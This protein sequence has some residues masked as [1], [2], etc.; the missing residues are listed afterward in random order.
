MPQTSVLIII[1]NYRT[2]A[3]ALEAAASLEAEVAARGDTHVVIVDNGSGDGSAEVLAAGIVERGMKKWC[4]LLP[5]AENRGFA[6]GNNQG[7]RWYEERTGALPDFTWL[8]NPDTTAHP[9]AIGA[10][11][12]FLT[13]QPRAGIVGSRCLWEDGRIR[14]SSFR[15]PSVATELAYAIGFGPITRLL[16]HRE[17]VLPIAEQPTRADWVSGSSFMIRRAVIERIGVMDEG[18]F[19]YFEESDYC[20]RAIDAGFEI[21]TVPESVITHIGG[22]ATGLTG[23]QRRLNR[24]PRY[25]FAARARFFV[26]RY[27][28][29]YANL[30]NILWLLAYPVGRLIGAI[31]R[32][33]RDEPPFFWWDFLTNYYGRRG[34]MYGI[35]K[36]RA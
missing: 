30:A 23:A 12:A 3:L 6:A 28:S 22:Q 27:G 20:A 4:D 16:G 10:L 8:L 32:K 36:I 15:F 2:P 14:F 19:L 9:G 31:R 7:L 33:R 1:V 13:D 26:R 24:R 25:W 18:Y 29:A 17:V 11:T 34:L 5:V 35:G 21:W